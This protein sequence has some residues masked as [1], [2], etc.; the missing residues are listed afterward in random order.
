MCVKQE[1]SDPQQ[2]RY[3]IFIKRSFICH[4]FCD[5]I[6]TINSFAY[7]YILL[8]TFNN[9]IETELQKKNGLDMPNRKRYCVITWNFDILP[10]RYMAYLIYKCQINIYNIK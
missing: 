6:Q 8:Y 10:E 9:Y 4:Q 2:C 3:L 5:T 1:E 7:I